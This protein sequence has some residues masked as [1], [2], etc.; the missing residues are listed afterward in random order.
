MSE[1][2]E[3]ELYWAARTRAPNNGASSP[4]VA[5]LRRYL[6]QQLVLNRVP[7]ADAGD[8]AG[9]LL[10]AIEEHEQTRAGDIIGFNTTDIAWNVL[11]VLD[12]EGTAWH[13]VFGDDRFDPDEVS[14][15]H[16]VVYDWACEGG[17]CTTEGLLF[18][19]PL[20][21]LRVAQRPDMAP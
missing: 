7:D 13:R 21:V 18:Y 8:V 1:M 9:R 16:L 4:E 19:K 17:R 11:E 15:D 6:H 5:Q 2:T 20:Q 3:R 14:D 10:D 12:D